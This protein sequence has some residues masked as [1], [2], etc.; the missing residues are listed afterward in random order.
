M[1]DGSKS[2]KECGILARG[3][4]LNEGILRQRVE[5]HIDV[6]GKVSGGGPSA[7]QSSANIILYSTPR[8]ADGSQ[9]EYESHLSLGGA[10]HGDLP[11]F[12]GYEDIRNIGCF[13]SHGG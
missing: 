7:Y 13:R 2:S 1:I 5:Y 8:A 4:D 12:S 6:K 3:S 9:R 10:A 11:A